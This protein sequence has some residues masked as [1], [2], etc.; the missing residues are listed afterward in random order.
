M[1]VHRAEKS[2]GVKPESAKPTCTNP[3]CQARYGT[4]KLFEFGDKNYNTTFISCHTDDLDMVSQSSSDVKEITDFLDKQFAHDGNP[5]VKVIDKSEVLGVK[6]VVKTL[7]GTRRLQ[8]LQDFKCHVY[9]WCDD[10][11]S[12]TH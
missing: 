8:L 7:N 9:A 11:Q 4:N 12:Q 6:R 10:S 5:G 2:R 1:Q 3:A